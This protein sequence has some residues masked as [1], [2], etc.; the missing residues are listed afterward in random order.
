MTT[1]ILQNGEMSQKQSDTSLITLNQ[2]IKEAL[3]QYLPSEDFTPTNGAIRFDMVDKDKLPSTPTVCVFL[4]DI[5][6]DLALRHGQPRHY[7][8]GEHSL[9]PRRVHI[10]CCYLLT[11]WGLSEH[12]SDVDSD[13][14]QVINM[15]LNALLNMQLPDT[16]VRIVA[17]SEHLSGL[18][19]F[20]QSMGD[21][22]RLS[23]NF[24][25]TVPV[26]LGLGS[27]DIR[28]P[29]ISTAVHV[30][31][32]LSWEQGD[33]ALQFRRQ[34]IE[35]CLGRPVAADQDART[36]LVRLQVSGVYTDAQG[37]DLPHPELAVSGL[38]SATVYSEVMSV[39]ES[40]KSDWKDRVTVN[41][42]KL[43]KIVVPA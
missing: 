16:Y 10:R 39:L 41:M 22:P 32:Q 27:P 13:Q 29:V 34:L 26:E 18:G 42:D 36:Q 11:C 7:Q 5:Q 30:E 37:T 25:V 14:V 38:L 33:L 20:W 17:P 24:T 40:M 2:K 43:Q 8:P 15:A 1:N 4:Y 35:L 12:H 6:E 31:P 28:P 9:S 21:K 23:L 19:N 3:L